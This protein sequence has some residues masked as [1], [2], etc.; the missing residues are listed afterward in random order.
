MSASLDVHIGAIVVRGIAVANAHRLGPAVAAELERRLAG[1]PAERAEPLR[2]PGAIAPE[3][4]ARA[5]AAAVHRELAARELT[6]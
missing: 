4:V 2:S 3:P 1:R 6:P 5:V